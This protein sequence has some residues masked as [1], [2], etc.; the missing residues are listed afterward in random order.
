MK[1]N[2]S[3]RDLCVLCVSAVVECA[4][5]IFTAENAEVAQRV[6]KKEQYVYSSR[7]CN[8]IRSVRSGMQFKGQPHRAPLERATKMHSGYKHVAPPERRQTTDNLSKAVL[9]SK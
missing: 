8:L 5:P 6:S 4:R 9:V 1:R 7:S 2:D 3:V